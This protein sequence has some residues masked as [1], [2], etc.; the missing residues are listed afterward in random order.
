[1]SSSWQWQ[2][3]AATVTVLAGVGGGYLLGLIS[4]K[5]LRKDE[6]RAQSERQLQ[7]P[8]VS[9]SPELTAA[10]AELTAEVARLRQA[11]EAGGLEQAS[12]RSMRTADSMSDFVSAQGDAPES[13]EDEDAFFD[14]AASK[15]VTGL[16]SY[17]CI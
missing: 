12:R 11:I 14:I 10:I 4:A 2:A 1:M 6:R 3:A 5:W 17:C 7:P 13:E 15:Y 8:L 16:P 9:S